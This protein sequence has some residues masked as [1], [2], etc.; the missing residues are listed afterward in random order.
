MLKSWRARSIVALGLLAAGCSAIDGLL[1]NPD[2]LAIQR[3]SVSP[4]EV[5]AGG[6]A[7]LSWNVE[8]AESV[9]IDNG[10]GVVKS[11]G[12]LEVRADRSKTYTLSARGGT[13]SASSTVQLLVTGSAAGPSP[14][15]S[16]TPTPSPTPSPT[17]T[18]SPS[19]TPTPSPSGSCRLPSMPECGRP[20]GPTG[21]WGCCREE[22]S[23]VFAEQVET[24]IDKIQQERPE[25]FNGDRPKDHDAYIQGVATILERDFG[26][27]S[28]QGGP[29][30]EVAVKNSNGFSEQ[31]D[32]LFS[33]GRI[34]RGGYTVT[35]RPARF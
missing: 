32:I 28:R 26:Y 23:Q 5:A 24:A 18:P 22:R 27:C 7:T 33:N 34:R 30:D 12:S 6:T 11:K 29:E 8:G 35:C 31:Y 14:S 3:F 25:L 1:N 21:V 4:K 20:E 2:S 13:S 9:Q 10:V 16:V 17:P 15:P 19:P